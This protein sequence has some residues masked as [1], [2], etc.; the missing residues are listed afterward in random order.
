[1]LRHPLTII[2]I[3]LL[4]GRLPSVAQP[5]NIAFKHIGIEQGLSNSTIE[6]IYQDS[7]GFIWLGTRDGLNRF[8]GHQFQVYRHRTGDSSSLTDNYIT[9]IREDAKGQLWIGTMNGLSR[10]NPKLNQFRNYRH[11]ENSADDLGH[12]QI[13]SIHIERRGRLWISSFGGGL[14][15]FDSNLQ[16]FKRI[17]NLRQKNPAAVE[18]YVHTIY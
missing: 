10:L 14:H 8:D 16:Q 4:L 11:Q 6:C 17:P 18:N 3:V 12:N 9:S 7:R 15:R 5:A 2:A 13:S 1:M